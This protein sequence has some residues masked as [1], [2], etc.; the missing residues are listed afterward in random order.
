M[1]FKENA[2]Q[3]MSFTD[4]FSGLTAR[5][6]K[7]LEKSWAKVFAD[8]IFPAIDEKRFSVLYSDKASR[9]NTPV[10]V[11]V[12]A[13]IIKELFDYSD[14]EMVENLMLDF[15]IQYAL[16]TTSFEEQPLSDKTLSRFRKRCYDYETLHNKDL[17]HD[18]VKELST[19]IAKLMGISGKVRR[20]DSMMIESKKFLHYL[21]V[22]S[23]F[24]TPCSVRMSQSM[25]GKQF[26]YLRLSLFFLC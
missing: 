8:E 12:G 11:I 18:C 20:M 10:N 19:S 26:K 1:S 23:I 17:Y 15:R 24:I 6:Q 7:A 16:H 21:L 5:E 22:Y 3:Q 2:Y 14:D 13:L 4:S 25:T 9:P